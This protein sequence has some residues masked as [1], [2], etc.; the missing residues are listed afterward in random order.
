M[1]SPICYKQFPRQPSCDPIIIFRSQQVVDIGWRV[2][3]V[4]VVED[5]MCMVSLY[6]GERGRQSSCVGGCHRYHQH[7]N[8]E[9]LKRHFCKN[10]G[11]DSSSN[12]YMVTLKQ[13]LGF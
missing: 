3:H 2:G 12:A 13:V 5:V 9:A 1:R 10:N 4:V 11:M 6:I 8:D 7:Q